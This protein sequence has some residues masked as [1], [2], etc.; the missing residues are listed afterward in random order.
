MLSCLQAG[1]KAGIAQV[2]RLS[3][4]ACVTVDTVTVAQKDDSKQWRSFGHCSVW[5][6]GQEA[7][8][9]ANFMQCV[10]REL[11][12][13]IEPALTALLERGCIDIHIHVHVYIQLHTNTVN[14]AGPSS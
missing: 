3:L 5:T 4:L 8:L 11:Q 10:V 7:Y 14:S 9:P 2:S 12:R 1:N 6:P 13:P